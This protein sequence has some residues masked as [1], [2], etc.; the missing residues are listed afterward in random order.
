MDITHFQIME[1]I[2]TLDHI[3]FSIACKLPQKKKILL[4]TLSGKR[5]RRDMKD[6][7]YA[8]ADLVNQY[9][10]ED[11]L[12]PI[13]VVDNGEAVGAAYT[14][15]HLAP[16]SLASK[17]GN[18]FFALETAFK[19]AKIL[20]TLHNRGFNHYEISPDTVW[21]D[22][23]GEQLKL[24]GGGRNSPG[25]DETDS[26]SYWMYKSPEQA[27]RLHTRTDK[28]TDFYSLGAVFFFIL[29]GVPP[30]SGKDALEL[31][32]NHMARQ[33]PDL[34]R[35]CP[36]VPDMLVRITAKLM[37][38]SPDKR[39]QSADSIMVDLKRCLS[40]LEKD[41][42]I[43]RFR[44]DVLKTSHLFEY[45]TRLF[46][47]DEALN[48][49]LLSFDRAAGQDCAV[50]LVTGGAGVGKTALVNV[51]EKKLPQDRGYFVGGKCENTT[52][53]I[54]YSGIIG[55]FKKIARRILME[56]DESYTAIASALRESLGRNAGVITQLI[57]QFKPILGEVPPFSDGQVLE[58][59]NRL[60]QCIQKI[61]RVV[62]RHKPFLVLFIDDLQWVDQAS[63]DLIRSILGSRTKG[64]FLIGAYRNLQVSPAHV[65]SRALARIEE[66][67]L[68]VDT[69][70]LCDL[71]RENIEEILK[72]AFKHEEKDIVSLAGVIHAKT[73][74]TPIVVKEF[75]DLLVRENY[76]FLN[77]RMAWEFDLEKIAS[78]RV[79]KD[80]DLLA[81]QKLGRLSKAVLKTVSVAAAIGNAFEL[82]ELA[83]YAG[84]GM[85]T[86]E[87]HLRSACRKNVLVSLGKGRYRFEHDP[88]R[89]NAY[90]MIPQEARK[91]LHIRLGIPLA[92]DV[93]GNQNRIFEHITHLNTAHDLAG[94]DLE[95]GELA[96][97]NLTA[98]VQAKK[99]AAFT[100]AF[101][102]FTI[103]IEVLGS[104]GWTE[105]YGLCLDLYSQGAVAAY[106][107]GFFKESD[108]LSRAVIQNGK[109]KTDQILG[110]EV[111]AESAIFM[112][113]TDH[114]LF[115][116][117]KAL[118]TLGVTLSLE[119]TKDQAR[120]EILKLKP[121]AASLVNGPCCL[122]DPSR[123]QTHQAV[124]R[125]L[126]QGA[127]ATGWIDYPLYWSMVGKMLEITHSHG[128]FEESVF[129]LVAA[130][131]TFCHLL[132][133]YDLG[134]RLAECGMAHMRQHHI[135]KWDLDA[136]IY[137]HEEITCLK[138][139][140]DVAVKQLSSLYYQAIE[141]GNIAMAVESAH[142]ACLIGLFGNMSLL[143]LEQLSIRFDEMLLVSFPGIKPLQS[144][145][146]VI[147]KI[148]QALLSP[149]PDAVIDT[150]LDVKSGHIN[151][152]LTLNLRLFL[153]TLL[154]NRA[155]ALTDAEQILP[156]GCSFVMIP[157]RFYLLLT[158]LG[159]PDMAPPDKRAVETFKRQLRHRTRASYDN[160]GHR[161]HLVL[162]EEK[163]R[164]EKWD[165]ALIHYDQAICLARKNRFVLDEAM[166][167][168][169]TA[170][171]FEHRGA[172][173][174]SDIYLEAAY[175]A[176]QKWGGRA[177]AHQLEN[178][179]PFLCGSGM[180]AH[181]RGR[182][183]QQAALRDGQASIMDMGSINRAVV[184]LVSAVDGITLLEEL[185]RI[186][187][188]NSGAERGYLLL[189]RNNNIVVEC[190]ASIQ[191]AVQALSPGTRMEEYEAM[192][193]SIVRYVCRTNKKF[194]S[195]NLAEDVQFG[196]TAYAK[197]TGLKSVLSM[198][199]AYRDQTV[200]FL[201]LENRHI[202]NTFSEKR[203]AVIRLLASQI[204]AALER[205]RLH[206]ELVQEIDNRKA[207]EQELRAALKRLNRLKK[208]LNEENEYLK[209]EIRNTHGFR[210]IVGKSEA[211]KKTLFL[212]EQVVAFDTTTLVLG[213]SGT[214][215]ELIARSIHELGPR[216]DHPIIKVN[217][218]ALPATLI[219][220]ELF[221]FEK[222]AFTGA[223]KSKKGRFSLADGGTL[224]LDEIGDMPM[225]V[226]VK[227]LRVL[228]EGAF[229]P[230]GSDKTLHVDVRVVAATNQDLE[231]AVSE[232]RFREDLYYRLSIFPIHVPPLRARKED[233]PLLVN[234][235]IDKKNK[236][237]NRT[238]KKIPGQ[239]LNALMAYDWP[240]NIR[241][242][243]N[244]IERAIIL[245]PGSTLVLGE[246]A[247]PGAGPRKA[248]PYT[249]LDKV[250]RRHI[251]DVLNSCHWRV[252]GK[253]NAAE[254]LGL[255]P[256]TLRS[257]M[258]K[259]G[260]DK[261]LALAGKNIDTV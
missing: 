180:P 148:V 102:Y 51:F 62:C 142:A 231:T 141:T 209:E 15:A 60:H 126:L 54:P 14:E 93:A 204:A 168:E 55:A 26:I 43:P 152:E 30:F 117:L 214:G 159:K 177:K 133:E 7:L 218:A 68:S 74:G 220:S 70:T 203:F 138:A 200:A 12:S 25:P 237:M 212:V 22:P 37:E 107:S 213:E 256:S 1:T 185:M 121:V 79:N 175:Q 221:G 40:A 188:Q 67:R 76:V 39:Y 144:N 246:G 167:L 182:A 35:I 63:M 164:E 165:E 202:T 234:Y 88:L 140:P 50:T 87:Q 46:G 47:R 49:L 160:Y 128:F 143:E 5:G 178:A 145:L 210:D 201:Y 216:K 257:K 80:I 71:D 112:N 6:R 116:L 243:E 189:E 196:Q 245:S 21:L 29:A 16:L 227:L 147:N 154:G 205:T 17:K 18:L 161:Y 181:R 255:N 249:R 233:I 75:I 115:I 127:R 163:K 230:L 137:L 72:A 179:H 135:K 105:H 207:K 156:Y 193:H 42:E 146:K 34:K 84:A 241:E 151:R 157:T 197:K 219:E 103:G 73:N 187:L 183:R 124:M 119:T 174:M 217:C 261:R 153:N 240:G 235:F 191:E 208:D 238:I 24:M 162:A 101:Q 95:K 132:E 228:Q 113:K 100:E 251:V 134:V 129:G 236:A 48:R 199:V 8:E 11:I 65:V 158:L 252:K 90:K 192:S 96:G 131:G 225:E 13:V 169:F 94:S 190:Q 86:V 111:Q 229:E 258:K 59:R 259:L 242:L 89:E 109:Q 44:L 250:I 41:G 244:T 248:M 194:L 66:T 224:F 136:R 3:C 206:R 27:G 186:L 4:K 108:A 33:V 91:K 226:Q 254:K 253:G 99:V 98:G 52:S 184:T 260:I 83:V 232:G 77:N 10:V 36:D 61:V 58:S 215:K 2:L 31:I 69:L 222:G 28:R 20:S 23:K 171:F 198:P 170:R 247:T 120:T 176:Y 166:A 106:L 45:P 239:T 139:H 125:L 118:D 92:R 150:T 57:P 172:G 9:K 173:Q 32:H 211:L 19:I 155:A 56:T 53:S 195:G 130:G 85:E 122:A 82:K 81:C 110:Y 104:R 78:V 97:L 149:D 123:K 223:V 64:L 114:A 38:K